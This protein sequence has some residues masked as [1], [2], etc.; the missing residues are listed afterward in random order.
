MRIAPATDV[1][2]VVADACRGIG[3]PTGGGRTMIDDARD[4]LGALGVRFIGSADV[5][6]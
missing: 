4:R 2:L 6:L 5:E 1:L 3:L